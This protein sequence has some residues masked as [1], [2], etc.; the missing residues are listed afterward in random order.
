MGKILGF[1]H[2]GSKGQIVIPKKVRKYLQVDEGDSI[3][4]I[5]DNEKV[6]IQSAE[7]DFKT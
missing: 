3:L 2:I 4:L 7:K 1:V 6:I 5:L